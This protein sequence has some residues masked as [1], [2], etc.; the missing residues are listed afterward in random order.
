MQEHCCGLLVS[1][2]VLPTGVIARD[3]APVSSVLYLNE[4]SV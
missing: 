1:T 3:Y 4:N 2:V